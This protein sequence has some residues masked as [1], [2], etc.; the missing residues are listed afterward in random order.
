MLRY[1]LEGSGLPLLLIHGWGVTYTTWENLAPLLT[2]YFQLIMIELPGIGGSQEI[3]HDMPYYPACAEAIEELR[4]SLGIEKW[5]VLAYSSGTRAAEAYI[6]RYPHSIERAIFLCPIYLAEIW[7]LLLHVLDNTPQ[8]TFRQWMLSNWRLYSLVLALG[9]NG[10]PHAYTQAWKKEIELQQCD[11]LIRTLCEMPGKGRAPFT[12]PA[13]PTLFIWSGRDRITPRPRRLRPNDVVI[14]ANH[15]APML[16]APRVAEVVIPFLLAPQADVWNGKKSESLPSLVALSEASHATRANPN[17]A[18][19]FAAGERLTPLHRA[20]KRRRARR[21]ATEQKR[22]S[23]LIHK[24]PLR[25][26][27]PRKKE[28]LPEKQATRQK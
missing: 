10:H 18:G 7:T 27:L 15:S 3:D 6:Q 28:A 14:P 23:T 20:W 8:P 11:I 25:H 13:L 19:T 22:L 2:P 24:A 16:A 1:R 5:S 21:N 17:R 4:Q 26:L 9:F 12:L